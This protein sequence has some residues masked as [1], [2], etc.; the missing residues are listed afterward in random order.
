MSNNTR[1]AKNA[2]WLSLRLILNTVISLFT[3]RV[4]LD[5]LGVDDFGV[6]GLVGGVTALFTILNGAMSSS[7][8][9]FITYELGRNDAKRLNETFS[10][11][12]WVHLGI[13]FLIAILC[14]TI[15]LWFLNSKLNIPSESMYAANWVYQFTILGMFMSITQVPYSACIMAHE[16]MGVYAYIEILH[17]CLKLVIVYLLLVVPG[18]KLIIYGLLQLLVSILILTI[19]RLYCIRK[20][21][22][23]KIRLSI[24]KE[25]TKSMF[26]FSAWT[27]FFSGCTMGRTQGL[28]FI[29]NIFFGVALNAAASIASIVSGVVGGLFSNILTAFRP[30]IIKQYAQENI[31]QMQMLMH[32]SYVFSS[33]V[34]AAMLIPIY[35]KID[36]VLNLWLVEVPEYVSIFIKIILFTS[37]IE[38]FNNVIN[39]VINATGKIKIPLL[40]TGPV[41]LLQLPLVWML[42]KV[43]RD[44][45]LSYYA[46]VFIIGII[47]IL[48]IFLVK[49]AVPSLK[50]KKT[51]SGILKCFCALG[52]GF[53]VMYVLH[54]LFFQLENW[55]SF[56]ICIVVSLIITVLSFYFIAF[57][58]SSREFIQTFLQNKIFHSCGLIKK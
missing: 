19:S 14:E 30:Q 8:S 3:S 33:F 40:C 46:T 55:G 47:L 35:F 45:A 26:S 51:I 32:R 6:Y 50:L 5:V 25:I 9:R 36:F 29:I 21:Q 37:F 2:V 42:F 34:C 31:I 38:V 11:S 52:V 17:T 43:H 56:L 53:S 54:N 12:F 24:N 7:T 23:A 13:A 1:V 20:F 28:N 16:K 27:L 10:A 15:G 22:E 57:D 18:D 58:K 44:P 4:V 49:R 48:N 39:A 41:Y